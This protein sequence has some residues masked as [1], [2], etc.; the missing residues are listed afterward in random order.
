MH[1]VL[2]STRDD[3]GTV[4]T[5]HV[6]NGDQPNEFLLYEDDGETLDYRKG[7][8][9]KRRIAFNPAAREIVFSQPEGKFESPFRK[10]RLVLHGFGD[11]R[12]ATVNGRNLALQSQVVRMLD[13]LQALIN[14]LVNVQLAPSKGMTLPF[15]SYGG[16][17]MLALSIE[18]GLLLAFTRRNPY[19]TRSPY[20]VKWSGERLTA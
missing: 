1:G 5:V 12:E 10:V 13:P 8:F 16:S 20:V 4:L 3:P 14:M 6:F 15:I 17:S 18:M 9:R 7:Q 19:L 11:G 2:Q